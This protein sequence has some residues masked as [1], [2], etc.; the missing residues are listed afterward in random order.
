MALLKKVLK[1]L[2]LAAAVLVGLL[3][4]LLVYSFLIDQWRFRNAAN[5]CERAC[6]QDSG[7]LFDCRKSCADHPLTYG[8][9]SQGH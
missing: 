2:L 1:R 8:P 7:G 9:A 6:I 4:A 5:P 3:I